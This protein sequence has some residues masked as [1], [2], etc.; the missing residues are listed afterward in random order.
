MHRESVACV[1]IQT[2]LN[3]YLRIAVASILASLVF[4]SVVSTVP[5]EED[6]NGYNPWIIMDRT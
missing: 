3:S 1:G 6:M 4:L 5:Y 2:L